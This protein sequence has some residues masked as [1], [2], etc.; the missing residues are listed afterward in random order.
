MI[1]G[2]NMMNQK[3]REIIIQ[4]LPVR[5]LAIAVTYPN[6]SL[7]GMGRNNRINNSDVCI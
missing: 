1:T 5:L 2:I 4:F 3:S 6:M 7:T